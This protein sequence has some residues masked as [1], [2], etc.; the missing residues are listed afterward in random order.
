[1]VEGSGQHHQEDHICKHNRAKTLDPK[2]Y[3]LD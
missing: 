1:M 3:K 2:P